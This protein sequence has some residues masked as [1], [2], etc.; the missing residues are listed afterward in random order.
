MSTRIAQLLDLLAVERT[1]VN[2]RESQVEFEGGY[3]TSTIRESD[4]QQL[5]EALNLFPTRDKVSL[6]VVVGNGESTT[7]TAGTLD[8][9]ASQLEELHQRV[10]IAEQHEFTLT[11]T[12][13]KATEN[14][15]TSVYLLPLFLT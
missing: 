4:A 13:I 1:T 9:V 7:I 12:I 10:L 14:G 6:A 15:E 8:E 3:S 5:L 2:E 11:L